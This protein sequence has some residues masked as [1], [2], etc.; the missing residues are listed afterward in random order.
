MLEYVFFD[1]SIADEFSRFVSQYQVK[2]R[3]VSDE[4][5]ITIEVAEDIED[6]IADKIDYEYERLLQKNAEILEQG[7]DALEKNVAGVQVALADGSG[8][9]IRIDP[10]FLSRILS[11]ISMEELRDFAQIIAE[12]VERRDNS[13]LC[14]VIE[15]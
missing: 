3:V 15:E 6:V 8:C 4:D 11:A 5:M 1:P 7:D 13:P 14:H 10:D 9:T 2:N 12:G